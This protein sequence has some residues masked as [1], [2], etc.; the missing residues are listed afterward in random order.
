M[1]HKRDHPEYK[2][3]PRRRR[4]AGGSTSTLSPGGSE[5]IPESCNGHNIA[6]SSY[7]TRSPQ[8]YKVCIA[9]ESALLIKNSHQNSACWSIV[10]NGYINTFIDV[11]DLMRKQHIYYR[12]SIQLEANKMRLCVGNKSVKVR[13]H[14]R[15]I[16]NDY[17]K[18]AWPSFSKLL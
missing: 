1:R 18:N 3:Q 12:L 15:I 6:S 17:N 16:I 10:F 9:S 5:G 11:G 7:S 4:M 2:Y 14:K 13:L 8:L